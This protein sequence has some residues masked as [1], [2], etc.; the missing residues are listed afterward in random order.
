M[1]T[2]E[3]IE[4]P[5]L[6]WV[7]INGPSG[8][9]RL[10]MFTGIAVF[11]WHGTDDDR[12]VSDP[13]HISMI[14]YDG[15]PRLFEDQIVDHVE[16]ASL[17]AIYSKETGRRDAVGFSVDSVRAFFTTRDDPDHEP[18]I[19]D[20]GINVQLSLLGNDVRFY[21]VS[22]QLNISARA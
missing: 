9:T 15:V 12:W 8:A 4:H 13:L 14:G 16:T 11:N 3:R 10:Y 1:P 7:N 21:R 6:L 19:A 5:Q 2:V 20:F 17:A 18:E 22:F